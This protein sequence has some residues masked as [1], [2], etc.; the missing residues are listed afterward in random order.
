MTVYSSRIYTVQ[1]TVCMCNATSATY[2][3]CQ[4][5]CSPTIHISVVK[6]NVVFT[7]PFLCAGWPCPDSG[8]PAQEVCRD[9]H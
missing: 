6:D 4:R 1:Y 8:G 9:Q 3:C 5:K 2:F 7:E